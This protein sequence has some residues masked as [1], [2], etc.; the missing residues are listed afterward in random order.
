MCRQIVNIDES[1]FAEMSDHSIRR[2]NDEV[3]RVTSNVCRLNDVL[4]TVEWLNQAYCVWV[5]ALVNVNADISTDDDWT[6]LCCTAFE[7]RRQFFKEYRRHGCQVDKL[8]VTQKSFLGQLIGCRKVVAAAAQCLHA[9]VTGAVNEAVGGVVATACALTWLEWRHSDSVPA[10]PPTCT[11]TWRWVEVLCRRRQHETITDHWRRERLRHVHIRVWVTT[12]ISVS[13]Y[14][15]WT[16]T[17]WR[18]T[19]INSRKLI[20]ST[21]VHVSHAWERRITWSPFRIQLVFHNW[22]IVKGSFW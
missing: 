13:K 16:V 3:E 15:Q 6:A 10:A 12:R 5:V 20:K 9:T 4:N 18:I 11:W 21:S 1:A 19:W 8:R 17:D 14:Q 2:G 7:D 22:K